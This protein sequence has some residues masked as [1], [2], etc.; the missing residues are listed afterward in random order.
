MALEKTI[1][2][3]S[4]DVDAASHVRPSALMHWMQQLAGDDLAQYGMTYPTMRQKGYVFVLFAL[5][6]QMDLPLKEGDNYTLQT[7]SIGTHGATFTRDFHFIKDGISIGRA[8]T[9]WVLLDF[10]KRRI[11]PPARLE[12]ELPHFPDKACGLDTDKR[13]EIPTDTVQDHRRVYP[14]ML[15]QNRHLNNCQYADLATDLLPP[16]P[17]QYVADLEILF[18]HEA[19]LGDRLELYTHTQPEAYLVHAYNTTRQTACFSAK[20]KTAPDRE[21]SYV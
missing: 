12:I 5:R 13:L 1:T 7:F 17:G 14:S 16:D 19:A 2:V 18:T 3:N 21:A 10:V 6:L 20:L 4:F 8:T 11:L 9:K 15:D